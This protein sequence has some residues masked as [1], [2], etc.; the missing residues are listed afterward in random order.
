M[1]PPLFLALLAVCSPAARAAIDFDTLMQQGRAA[2]TAADFPGAAGYFAQACGSDPM[3][4]SPPARAAYCQ[5]HLATLSSAM[6]DAPGAERHYLGASDRWQAAGSAYAAPHCATMMNLGEVYRRLHREKDSEAAFLKAAEL[7]RAADRPDLYA[8]VL[9]RLGVL[10]HESMRLEPARTTLMEAI[11]R[12]E[13]LSTP[14]PAEEA[15]A[16]NG[17]GMVQLGD[18]QQAEA[19]ANLR[20]AV[21]L[22]TAALGEDNA[23]TASYQ[24]NLALALIV[25]GQF[26]RANSLLRRAKLVL[27]AH[28]AGLDTQKGLVLAELS[29]AAAGQNK[30]GMAEEYGAQALSTLSRQKDP[31][32]TAIALAR[33]NL[34]DIYLRARRLDDANRILPD[35]VAAERVLAPDTRLLA[36]GLRRLAELRSLQHAWR[37]AQDL[38]R[39]AIALYERRLGPNHPALAPVLRGYAEALKHDGGSKSDVRTLEARAKAVA[40]SPPRS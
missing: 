20:L 12:F 29:A 17:L 22:A 10:Y 36:D 24:T 3:S 19:E 33:V 1:R 39:E 8:E 40:S 37:E 18:G 30:L 38:Y 14:V 4:L 2:L 11:R 15:Y 32:P 26:D 5:H 21:S 23:E 16:R 9:G 28:G 7:A 6:G 13:K 34:A 27:D 35:A 25:A 31:N